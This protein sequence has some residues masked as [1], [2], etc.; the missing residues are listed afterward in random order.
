MAALTMLEK[1]AFVGPIAIVNGVGYWWLNHH[2]RTP[3]LLPLSPLDRAVPFLPWTLW[4]YMVLFVS[5]VVLPLSLRDRRVFRDVVLAYVVAI[6]CNVVLWNLYP[7]TYPRPDPPLGP[8]ITDASFRIMMAVDSPN[9]C[10]PSGHITIPAVGC[11]GLAREHPR[12]RTAI[13]A[14][15]AL[16]SLTVLSTKQHYAVDILGGFGTAL[17]GIVVVR[18]RSKAEAGAEG[19]PC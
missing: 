7:T 12:W 3:A 19:R 4:P 10:F 11:W 5:D 9:V 15:F 14:V 8:S 6:L 16:L 2:L 1:A 18:R 13:W 17:V